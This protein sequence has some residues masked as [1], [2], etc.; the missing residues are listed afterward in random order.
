MTVLSYLRTLFSPFSGKN[1]LR[2]KIQFVYHFALLVE[3]GN[4]VSKHTVAGILVQCMAALDTTWHV[5]NTR[6]N[7]AT[8][9]TTPELPRPMLPVSQVIYRYC[10]WL[11]ARTGIYGS[12]FDSLWL[13]FAALPCRA[14]ITCCYFISISLHIFLRMIE[15]LEHWL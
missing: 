5:Q 13:L 2:P 9:I 1:V 14:G 6:R 11:P 15:M 8:Y 3:E 10:K 12:N 4:C 7:M